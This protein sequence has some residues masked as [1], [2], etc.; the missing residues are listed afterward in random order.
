MAGGKDKNIYEGDKG[1][2]LAQYL[3]SFIGLPLPVLRQVDIGIDFYCNISDDSQKLL[4]F[5]HPFSIQIKKLNEK[6]DRLS[7]QISYGGITKKKKWKR[8]EID[9]LFNPGVP[10]FIGLVDSKRRNLLIYSTSATWF[11]YHGQSVP[12]KIILE[13]RIYSDSNDLVH[14]P[15]TKEI[16]SLKGETIYGDGKEHIV[17]LGDPIIEIDINAIEDKEKISHLKNALRKFID[18]I[19]Q[20]NIIQRKLRSSFF[21]W[22][23]DMKNG[24]WAWHVNPYSPNFDY[25]KC[26][27]E[28][29]PIIT[30]LALQYKQTND[31]EKFNQIIG[32]LQLIGDRI[33]ENIRI[34]LGIKLN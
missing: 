19:E 1:E 13:P 14:G 21:W 17:D 4:T 27:E 12:T 20:R 15:K 34:I 25:Q 6:D 23:K 24:Q 11:S 32:V 33:P 7:Q 30:P 31:T 18:N 5:S 28:L 10:F 26:L 2:Y 9:W 8:Y 16:E 22:N 29:V 3:L